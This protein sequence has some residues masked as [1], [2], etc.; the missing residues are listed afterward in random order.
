M[1]FP[2]M[3]ERYNWH[4]TVRRE[5]NKM[6]GMLEDVYEEMPSEKLMAV[7]KLLRKLKAQGENIEERARQAEYD[8]AIKMINELPHAQRTWLLNYQDREQ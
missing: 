7:I 5:L 3:P 6:I 2:T 4:M 1:Q 8:Q